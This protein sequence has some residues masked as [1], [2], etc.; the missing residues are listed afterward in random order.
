MA[1][2]V[3]NGPRM[4]TAEVDRLFESVKN[5]GR[6]GP[7]DQRGALDCNTPEEVR[8]ATAPLRGDG[9]GGEPLRVG[10]HEGRGCGARG[11]DRRPAA[12]RRDLDGAGRGG[13]AG[14]AGG[15]RKGAGGDDP[16]GGHRALAQRPRA[17]A[18]R[19]GAVGRV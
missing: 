9:G 10:G 12:A 16:P 8:A 4:T 11:A 3:D 13:A 19:A 2:R 15:G 6:W 14:G 18:A 5:W 7:D 1:T 17:A